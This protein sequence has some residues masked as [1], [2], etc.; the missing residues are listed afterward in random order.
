MTFPD[1]KVLT[2][3]INEEQISGR[4]LTLHIDYQDVLNADG[5]HHTLK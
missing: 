1:E 2:I 3:T 4:G 5:Y